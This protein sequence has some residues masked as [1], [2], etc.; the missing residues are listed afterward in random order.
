YAD[1]SVRG[2]R[3][4]EP[5]VAG[6][7]LGGQHTR[8]VEEERDDDLPRLVGD[9]Q[10]R[11]LMAIKTRGMQAPLNFVP[12]TYNDMY[13]LLAQV[14]QALLLELLQAFNRTRNKLLA[15]SAW[16]QQ[17]MACE[18]ALE[19]SD[20]TMGTDCE[21]AAPTATTLSCQPSPPLAPHSTAGCGM[22][23]GSDVATRFDSALEAVLSHASAHDLMAIKLRG[24]HTP[25]NFVSKTYNDIY[26][27]LTQ[28]EQPLLIQLLRAFSRKNK[29]LLAEAG[30][31]QGSTIQEAALTAPDPAMHPV[32]SDASSPTATTLPRQAGQP[33]APPSA[34]ARA[35]AKC[36]IEARGW[37]CDAAG[38]DAAASLPPSKRPRR[39]A[40]ALISSAPLGSSAQGTP[41]RRCPS[42]AAGCAD[43]TASTTNAVG[44]TLPAAPQLVG[45]PGVSVGVSKGRARPASR[46][47]AEA[48]ALWEQAEQV[49][50]GG[51]DDGEA[52]L[53]SSHHDTAGQD[54]DAQENNQ[55][56]S[57]LPDAGSNAWYPDSSGWGPRRGWGPRQVE[58][59]V[60]GHALGVQYTRAAEEEEEAWEGQPAMKP[61][62]WLPSMQVTRQP[63]VSSHRQRLQLLLSQKHCAAQSECA[64]SWDD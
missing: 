50:E 37:P 44:M 61:A 20:P 34:A 19:A 38:S 14:D 59:D 35:K 18:A 63:A 52:M 1:S 43:T 47:W 27:L 5:D 8:A 39:S 58:A 3:R 15:E 23:K 48:D 62:S 31:Q 40:M 4:A 49:H 45:A 42:A 6:H 36:S 13:E 30:R 51:G 2:P 60:A 21:D 32:W 7:A 9:C 57:L 46:G 24:M 16:Q 25:L 55:V 28:M 33:L 12:E 41:T 29:K 56:G 64:T 10:V 54:C 11:D 53:P 17:R 26:E 22:A